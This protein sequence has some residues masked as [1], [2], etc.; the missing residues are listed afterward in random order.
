MAMKRNSVLADLLSVLAPDHINAIVMDDK[1]R[2]E[3]VKLAR[4]NDDTIRR[5]I[6]DFVGTK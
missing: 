4:S 3:S 1:L 5:R 6:N 2:N